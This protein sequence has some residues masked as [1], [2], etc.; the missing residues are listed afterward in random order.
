MTV[1]PPPDAGESFKF[2]MDVDGELPQM[3]RLLEVAHSNG[4]AAVLHTGTRSVNDYP[5]TLAVTADD[6]MFRDA[7]EALDAIRQFA[8]AAVTPPPA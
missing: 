2:A 7:I 4:L 6:G 3:I 8:T 5:C 1:V